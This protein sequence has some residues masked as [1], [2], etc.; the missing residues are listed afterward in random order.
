MQSS[1]DKKEKYIQRRQGPLSAEKRIKAQFLLRCLSSTRGQIFFFFFFGS[2]G[3]PDPYEVFIEKIVRGWQIP[4][5][6]Y[7]L[8]QSQQHRPLQVDSRS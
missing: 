1:L 7:S 6:L 5:T 4:S 8:F 2:G 3:G